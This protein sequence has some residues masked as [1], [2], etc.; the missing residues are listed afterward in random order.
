MGV[1]ILYLK[2][3]SDII[4]I[5]EGGK[6]TGRDAILIVVL[7]GC[8]A[9][10]VM[11][12]ALTSSLGLRKDMDLLVVEIASPQDLFDMGLGFVNGFPMLLGFKSGFLVK[13]WEGF[14]HIDADKEAI[15]SIEKALY[16]L[17]SAN[18]DNVIDL[19]A[20]MS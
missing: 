19:L 13:G 2:N 14:D 7:K 4:N 3:K 18:T 12:K 16:E 15:E 11:L 10:K 8:R 1:A 17:S 5:L 20:V 9:C 6:E